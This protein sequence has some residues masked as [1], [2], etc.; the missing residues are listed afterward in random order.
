MQHGPNRILR[1]HHAAAVTQVSRRQSEISGVEGAESRGLNR[2]D[3]IGMRLRRFGPSV[4]LE[5][6]CLARG[7]ELRD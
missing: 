1:R 6:A 4:R 5:G 7:A 3:A 2:P